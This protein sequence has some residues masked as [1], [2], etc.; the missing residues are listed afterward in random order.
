MT[1]KEFCFFSHFLCIVK[2][3]VAK[4]PLAIQRQFLLRKTTI[5][6]NPNAFPL[7]R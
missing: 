6:I 1:Q 7:L 4:K 5:K 2:E 3:S